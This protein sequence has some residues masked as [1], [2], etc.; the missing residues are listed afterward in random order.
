MRRWRR[1]DT[2]GD[3]PNDFIRGVTKTTHCEHTIVAQMTHCV[4]DVYARMCGT[5]SPTSN[6]CSLFDSAK[7]LR[8]FSSYLNFVFKIKGR[9]SSPLPLRIS[10]A[11]HD[12]VPPPRAILMPSIPPACLARRSP[13]LP[14]YKAKGPDLLKLFVGT[15]DD[16]RGLRFTKYETGAF[17]RSWARGSSTSLSNASLEAAEETARMFLWG[18]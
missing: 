3:I 15:S 7:C 9:V 13:P 12:A 14:K 4:M 17:F 5:A 10:S 2:E 1:R 11:L 6:C 16:K 18:R 8:F